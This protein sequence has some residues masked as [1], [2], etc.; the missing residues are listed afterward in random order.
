MV[1]LWNTEDAMTDDSKKTDWS[2]VDRTVSSRDLPAVVPVAG[3]ALTPSAPEAVGGVVQRFKEGK[4][5]REATI[6]KLQAMAAAQFD[7]LSHQLREASKVKKA[8]AT[9][10]AERFLKEIDLQFQEVAQQLGVRNEAIRR[11]T[12]KTLSD[13]TARDLQEIQNKDWPDFMV[14]TTVEAIKT[15]WNKFV[16]DLMKDLGDDE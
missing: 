4:I 11:E 3:E 9:V 7:V 16:A 12:L 10:T 1:D 5:K 6:Q 14:D 13:E 8:E 15:R 2:R